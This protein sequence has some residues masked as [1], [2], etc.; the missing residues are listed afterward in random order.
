MVQQYTY[1]EQNI[2]INKLYALTHGVVLVYIKLLGLPV[3]SRERQDKKAYA[4]VQ[5][6]AHSIVIYGLQFEDMNQ[7]VVVTTGKLTNCFIH[8]VPMH[9]P[10]YNDICG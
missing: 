7:T 10:V 1:Y 4:C 3:H 2:L 5:S 6:L 8:A 9:S